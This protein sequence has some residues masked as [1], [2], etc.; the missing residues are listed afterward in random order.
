MQLTTL[1]GSAKKNGNTATILGWVEEK[2]ESLDHD[3]EMNSG[4]FTG[5][6]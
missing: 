1:L 2:F 5:N 4:P 3:V 6:Q